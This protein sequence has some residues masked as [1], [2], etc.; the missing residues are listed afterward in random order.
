MKYWIISDTHFGHD[1]IKKYCNRPDDCDEQ[2]LKNLKNIPQDDILIHLGDFCL[3]NDEYWHKRFFEI[4]K[5]KA[6]LVK[7]N[8]DKK[9]Y[10]WY[11][12]NGWN[13]VCEKFDFKH[14]GKYITFSHIPQKITNIN[15]H[16][17]YHDTLP[18]LLRDENVVKGEKE[19]NDTDFVL[20]NYNLKFHKLVSIEKDYNNF[21][22]VLLDSLIK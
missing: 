19:R 22:P 11:Y 14:E 9:S 6:I 4:V 10:S 12:K 1:N 13:F 21:K 3:G 18:R 2:I 15:I 8:H 5:C 7:G 17:H 16:G 20:S